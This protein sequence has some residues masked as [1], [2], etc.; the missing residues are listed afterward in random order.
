MGFAQSSALPPTP[1][2]VLPAAPAAVTAA[3]AR[4]TAAT[5]AQPATIIY[6]DGRLAVVAD[7]SSLN[8]MLREIA[9][10][11]GM[12]VTGG[13]AEERVF[14]AYGPGPLGKVLATLLDGTGSNML[15][16]QSSSGAPPELVLTPV[17][18]GPSPPNPNAAAYNDVDTAQPQPFVPQQPLPASG[19]PPGMAPGYGPGYAPGPGPSPYSAVTPGNGSDAQS[20][21]AS[22]PQSPNG[23]KT[24][25]QIFQQLQ[26]LQQQQQQP[27]K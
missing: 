7:N 11:S 9:R 22:N 25:Q 8:Q 17:T 16:R 15:L 10:K 21:G 4:A 6:A 3:P 14:G 24:P 19:L 5:P 1:P 12:T 2:T 27:P 26:Q 20:N 13:V 18:G 23:V